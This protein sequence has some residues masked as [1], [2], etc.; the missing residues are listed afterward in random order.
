MNVVLDQFLLIKV[1]WNCVKT[2]DTSP[3]PANEK[4]KMVQH[5]AFTEG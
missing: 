5:R 2:D 3:Q 1:C 4:R